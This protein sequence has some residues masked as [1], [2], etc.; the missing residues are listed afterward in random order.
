LASPLA[1]CCHQHCPSRNVSLSSCLLG[2][3]HA[4]RAFRSLLLSAQV[5]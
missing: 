2:L 1:C 4:P 3:T 5:T